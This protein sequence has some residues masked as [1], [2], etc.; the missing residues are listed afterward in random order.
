[1]DSVRMMGLAARWRKVHGDIDF[2][3]LAK[4]PT[5][6]AWW[7][8]LSRGVAPHMH[9]NL[10]KNNFMNIRLGFDTLIPFSKPD[11]ETLK[12]LWNINNK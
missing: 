8:L 6:D 12:P 9:L 2:V 7:A 4:N 3:M 1:L 10:N 11:S 5:I